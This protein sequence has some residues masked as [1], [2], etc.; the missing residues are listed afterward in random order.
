M[1]L[2]KKFSDWLTRKSSL[3]AR[4]HI[5]SFSEGEVFWCSLGENIGDEECGKGSEFTRPVLVLRKF[6]KHIFL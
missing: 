2:Y 5:P 4:S 6:N 3:D 1:Q